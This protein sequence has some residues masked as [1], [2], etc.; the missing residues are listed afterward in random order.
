M[1]EH[2]V[3]TSASPPQL[4]RRMSMAEQHEYLRDEAVP[5]RRAGDRRALRGRRAAGR[6]LGRRARRGRGAPDGAR[7]SRP[8]VTATGRVHGSAGRPLRPPSRLRRR[9]EDPDADLLAGAVRGQEAV[10]CGS[11]SKPWDLSR[12]IEAEVRDLHTP[13]LSKKLP[14][15]EQ[16]YLHAALD[17]LR[18]RHDVL[19]RRRPRGLRPGVGRTPARRSARSPRRPRAPETVRLHGLRRPGRQLRRARQRPADPRPE[20]VLPPARGRHLL[21]GH[22][23]PR[24]GVGHLRRP[25]LGP[26]PRADRV[27]RQVACRGW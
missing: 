26:V 21:R 6:L 8:R 12:K 4:A 13:S 7:R 9:P 23:G 19:L 16:Y 2:P 25:G 17:G 5:P 27:G 10:S 22:H 3:P 11:G 1:P 15:V 18:A 20:P 14:A 24:Q